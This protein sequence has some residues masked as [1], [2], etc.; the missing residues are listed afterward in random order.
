M[1]TL[2]Q[3]AQPDPLQKRRRRVL[4]IEDN[5]DGRESL[6]AVLEIWGFEVEAAEDGQKGVDMALTWNPDYA[7][8]DINLPIIDGYEV[9]RRVRLALGADVFLVA[10]TAHGQSEDRRAAFG[11]GFDAHLTKP[12]NL[13]TLACLLGEG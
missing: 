13:G 5:K 2:T 9:A 12:A 4:V 11:A 1:S 3:A 8:V 7:V 10:L 6:C